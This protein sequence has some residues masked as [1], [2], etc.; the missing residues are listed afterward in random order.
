MVS[1]P[2][3]QKLPSLE[4]SP[5]ENI[6]RG[7]KFS[8][9]KDELSLLRAVS[10]GNMGTEITLQAGQPARVLRGLSHRAASCF[11]MHPRLQSNLSF[12][13]ET[14]QPAREATCK[15]MW[16]KGRRVELE[17]F[18]PLIS[19]TSSINSTS[20]APVQVSPKLCL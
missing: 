12:K 10:G 5:K 11:S 3:S 7:N 15:E 8:A 20:S 16:K 18:N 17:T 2:A 14:L 9:A 6:C 4:A 1:F 13:G 19:Q